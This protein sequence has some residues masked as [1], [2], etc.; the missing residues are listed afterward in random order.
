VGVRPGPVEAR[1]PEGADPGRR[2]ERIVLA[3]DGSAAG[4]AAMRWLAARAG[5]RHLDVQI[6]VVE[7]ASSATSPEHTAWQAREYL[8]ALAPGTRLTIALLKGDPRPALVTASSDTDLL[9]LG[10]KRSDRLP[11]LSV[12]TLSTHLAESAAC[13]TV[14][15]PL[16]WSPHAGPVVVGVGD[17]DGDRAALAFAVEEAEHSTRD[18]L[19]LH[20]RHLP[21]AVNPVVAAELDPYEAEPGSRRR[22]EETVA[23]VRAAH[24]EL[25]VRAVLEQEDPATALR[26]AGRDAALIVMGAHRLTGLQRAWAG[27]T[28]DETLRLLGS[29]PA[30]L[31]ED[32]AAAAAALVGP[33]MIRRRRVGAARVF[34][35][36]FRNAVLVMLLVTAVVAALLGDVS[37]AVIVGAILLASIALGFVNEYRAELSTAR[38]Q[39]SLAHTAVVVRDGSARNVPVAALVPGDVIRLTMGALVPADVRI[40]EAHALECDESVLTGEALPAEKSASPMKGSALGDL[41]SMAFMGT[42]VHS[43]TGTAVVVSTGARTELGRMAAELDTAVPETAFQAGLRHFSVLLMLVGGTLVASILL[44]GALLGRPLLDSILFAL[45]IAVGITPQLLPAVVGTSLAAGARSLAKRRV[46]VKRLVC[47]EDLGNIDVLV[48]DKTGTLTEGRI[49]FDRSVA[50]D[51]TDDP[52]VAL[53]ASRMTPDRGDAAASGSTDALDA[54]LAAVVRSRMPHLSAASL[55]DTVPFDHDRRTASALVVTGPGAVPELVVKGAPEVVLASCADVPAAASATLEG[56]L[57]AGSRTVAVASRSAPGERS[58]SP[59]DGTGLTL[60]GFLAFT[61]PPRADAAAS[62]Q[63]LADLSVRMI[64]ATGDHPAVAEHVATRLGFPAGRTLTGADVDSLDDRLL[65]ARLADT[66]I[67]ARVSPRQK[68]RAVRL[69]RGEGR[70]VGFLG[71]GVNDALALHAADVGISVDT[72]TDVAKDAADVVLLEKS[73]DVVAEGVQEGRRIFANTIKYVFMAAS[74]NF[75]NMISAAAA[76]AFLPF[77]PML[78]GQILLGN[79]LYDASQLTIATDRVDEESLRAPSHWDIAAIRRFMLIF[80]PLSSVFDLATFAL[81]IGVFRAPEAEFHT[82]WFVESMA[83]QALVVFVIRTRRVPFLRSRPSRPLVAAVLGV[84]AV[85]FAL[86]VTPLAP[87]LGFVPL[88]WPLLAAVAAMAVG[89]LALAELAKYVFYRAEARRAL[90]L[91]PAHRVRRVVDKYIGAAGV[92]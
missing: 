32:A 62:L 48:T 74:S 45:A 22:L 57:A 73:L 8:D 12:A 87:V 46:L 33:N 77:L 71:D 14:L 52:G 83:T 16:N 43:G 23:A 56:L 25:T 26:G 35:R 61:D 88:G 79:L 4:L 86:P 63:R 68:A 70:T 89:Y 47:I 91:H 30:G 9:V 34:G 80:G 29:S 1:A 51:G 31:S 72:A 58:C 20:A 40:L 85:A 50:P 6:A 66:R 55:L 19:V 49:R 39:D 28:A 90:P 75:G 54:E 65:A 18:L 92:R 82:G 41:S 11:S 69:L 67:L 13:P 7:D 60:R 5:E 78:P 3:T 64:V 84:L 59:E 17:A 37:D 27:T 53:L 10:T 76:S 15:V 81:L 2:T 38:L 36:Q 21:L 42:L 24:P 44:T